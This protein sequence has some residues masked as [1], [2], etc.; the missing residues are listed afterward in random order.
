M[1]HVVVKWLAW[2]AIAAIAYATLARVGFVY[3]IYFKVAPLVMHPEM[4]A[5]AHF[6]HVLAFMTLGMLFG[7]AYPHRLLWVCLLVL[8]TAILLEVMQ[9][10]TPDRHATVM[11]AAEKMVGGAVGIFLPRGIVWARRR[12]QRKF[13]CD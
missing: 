5:Y 9:T 7:C 12:A 11:D 2:L 13:N 3:E 8:G 6:V 1:R 10:T 4:K